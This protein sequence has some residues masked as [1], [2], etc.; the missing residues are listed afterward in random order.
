MNKRSVSFKKAYLSSLPSIA[1]THSD[2]LPNWMYYRTDGCMCGCSRAGTD[3][4]CRE[5]GMFEH[6]VI[7]P[8]YEKLAKFFDQN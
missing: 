1:M 2:H 5:C 3:R 4:M 6:D 8:K 7:E